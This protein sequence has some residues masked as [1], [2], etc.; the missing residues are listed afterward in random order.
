[1][2]KN[3][4][5]RLAAPRTWNIQRKKT[6]YIA[7]PKPGAHSFDYGMPL[8]VVLRDLLKI[9]NTSKEAKFILNNKDVI[10]NGKI[11]QA[12]RRVVGLMD[13]ISLPKIKLHLRVLLNSKNQL[14]FVEIDDKDAK[15]RIAKINNKSFGK[16]GKK[17]LHLHDGT[18]LFAKEDFKTG[19]SVLI[20]NA[21]GKISKRFEFKKDVA[22][23][24]TGGKHIGT[25]GNVIEIIKKKQYAD[26]IVV[27]TKSEQFTTLKKYAYVIGEK[28][29]VI[30]V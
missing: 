10:L 15:N 23:L 14:T 16:G 6:P 20:D 24:L 9:T 11:V 1:M 2:V 7:R 21:T 26:Q 8:I 17:T 19:D 5:L 12:P 30:K 13:V 29:P 22:V 4:L 3:H 25:V 27:K 18:N 28:E